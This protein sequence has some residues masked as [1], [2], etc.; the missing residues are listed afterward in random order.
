[1]IESDTKH[2][3]RYLKK[4]LDKHASASLCFPFAGPHSHLSKAM[5]KQEAGFIL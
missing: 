2:N 5:A 3:D 1:M 4:R